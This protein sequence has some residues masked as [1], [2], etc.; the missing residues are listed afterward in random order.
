M[1]NYYLKKLINPFAIGMV[2][3]GELVAV[4]MHLF[5]RDAEIRVIFNGRFMVIKSDQ[6]PLTTR[7]FPDKFNRS[8]FYT[9]CY[10]EWKPI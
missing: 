10:Y 1:T 9:L 3:E 2:A 6:K 5:K 8:K 4:P 7:D